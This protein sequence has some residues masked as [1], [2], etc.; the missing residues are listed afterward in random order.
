MDDR[1]QKE[2]DEVMHHIREANKAFDHKQCNRKHI[3]VRYED[4]NNWEFAV[5]RTG[6]EIRLAV[7]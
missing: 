6:N 2:W 7:F 3:T 1:Q 5:I 4:G